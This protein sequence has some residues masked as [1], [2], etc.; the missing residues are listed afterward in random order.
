MDVSVI[1]VNYKTSALISDCVRSILEKTKDLKYEVIIVDNDSEPDF[2]EKISEVIPEEMAERFSFLPLSENV[3]FGR[4]NNEGLKR[5]KGRNIFFLNPDTVLVNDAIGILSQF[6][7]SRPDVGACGGN[8]YNG[9]LQPV[10]S[11][12]RISPGI[13]W[14]TN[15]LLNVL[16]QK[17]L[18][19][20]NA[21]HNHT[22][23]PFEVAFINGADLMVK[24]EV[25]DRIGSF[26]P[27]FFMYF[28]ETDLCR[29]IRRAGLKI[30]SVPE[31]KIEHLESKSF[32]PTQKYES[33][34]KTRLL[35][36][37]RLIYYRR[38]NSGLNRR[39]SDLIYLMYL[40]SR[41]L[42]IRNVVKKEYYELR[43]KTFKENKR[44]KA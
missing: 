17:M 20:K 38:N 18:F 27:E 40:K 35:E 37:S 24:K 29:R 15:V 34:F 9:D 42:L 39:L 14:E 7:D 8:L 32:D 21:V 10:H 12:R 1:I 26:S 36:E 4:A 25:L 11:F 22:G 43:L 13:L 30:V 19:G 31:A 3:G 6:L 41:A 23:G 28:E 44:K 16:P 33:E 2:K 5:A